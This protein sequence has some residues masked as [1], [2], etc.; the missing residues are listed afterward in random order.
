M[1]KKRMTQEELDN[2]VVQH[3]KYVE[4]DTVGAKLSLSQIT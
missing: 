3:N 1:E 2:A 4:D